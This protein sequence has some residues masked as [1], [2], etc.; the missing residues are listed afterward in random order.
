MSI[1]RIAPIPGDGIRREVVPAA[2]AVLEAVGSRHGITFAYDEFDWSC[3]RYLDEGAMM[4]SDGLEQVRHHDAIFL[5][6]IGAPGVPDHVSLWGLLIPIRRLPRG[7]G[8]AGGSLLGGTA[9]TA[10][11][12]KALLELLG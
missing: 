9:T 12:T 8:R 1:H 11:F 4:P 10:D 2:L 7:A 5:G 6:A 3:R